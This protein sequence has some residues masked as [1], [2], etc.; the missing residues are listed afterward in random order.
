MTTAKAI[1]ERTYSWTGGF[2]ANGNAQ[3]FGEFVE[4][5]GEK[6][7][8]ETLV[9]LAAPKKCPIHDMFTWDNE[10]AGHEY[11]LLEARKM[12]GSY[13]VS[14]RYV[15]PKRAIETSTEVKVRV[16]PSKESVPTRARIHVKTHKLGSTYVSPKVLRNDKDAHNS[17]INECLRY[18][19]GYRERF[20]YLTELDSVWKEIDKAR[21]KFARKV[22]GLN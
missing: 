18:L 19:C 12:L 17:A 14:V 4:G 21:D 5:I 2:R 9:E 8:A 10:A 20:S 15:Q 11:R 6:C 1:E 16:T 22:A 7:D 13:R 3:V